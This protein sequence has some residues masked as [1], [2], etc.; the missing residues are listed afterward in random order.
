ML[1]QIFQTVVFGNEFEGRLFA[2]ARHSRD[3]VAGVSGQGPDIYQ[4]PRG[5]A[6][7]FLDHLGVVAHVLHGIPHGHPFLDQGQEVFVP[8][9]DLHLKPRLF[10][11]VH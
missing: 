8:G 6:V 11:P 10:G 1:Q 7:F 4:L 9:D 3:I 2:D 5:E